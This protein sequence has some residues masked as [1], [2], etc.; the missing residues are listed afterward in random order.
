[1]NYIKTSMLLA[2]LTSL[3]VGAGFMLGGQG[4]MVIAILIALAMNVGS[5][6]FSDKI[7]LKMY[8]AKPIESGDIYDMVHELAIS[9][10]MPMP[11]V[12]M[13]DT[14]QPNAFATGRNPENGAVAVTRPIPIVALN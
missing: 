1:M 4:G 11:K 5:Y 14:M 2:V 12:Y 7:V 3:F 8:G 13:M 6:W 9:A 10:A